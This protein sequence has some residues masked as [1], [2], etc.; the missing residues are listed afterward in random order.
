[1][2]NE[3]KIL[4]NE[5]LSDFLKRLSG[6]RPDGNAKVEVAY[7]FYTME[8]ENKDTA[9]YHLSHNKMYVNLYFDKV[10]PGFFQMDI[11]FRD[12]TEYELIKLWDRLE[13]HKKNCV[14]NP[15]KTPIFY[16]NLME[17]AS[18]EDATIEKDT[19]NSILIA[20]IMNPAVSILTREKPSTLS[21]DRVS[22]NLYNDEEML[23][24]GNILRLL[25]PSELVNFE[26]RT[27]IDLYKEAVEEDLIKKDREYRDNYDD[28]NSEI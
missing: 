25:I 3:N 5:E 1:M 17:V 4:T 20:N 2:E 10:L 11:L 19:T 22:T 15:D 28:W 8:D 21:D 26:L 14:E 9:I 13:K 12:Y 23:Q 7:Q 18:V 24:G 6:I 27:D 16:F